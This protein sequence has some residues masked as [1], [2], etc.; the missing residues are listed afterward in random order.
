MLS[1][2]AILA[3]ATPMIGHGF[4]GGL[5]FS[6]SWNRSLSQSLPV[7]HNRQSYKPTKQMGFPSKVVNFWQELKWDWNESGT[8]T[9][10][11]Y[12]FPQSERVSGQ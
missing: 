12:D 10:A 2:D 1:V 4:H 3:P 9:V 6:P 7:F 8:D 11:L 5:T